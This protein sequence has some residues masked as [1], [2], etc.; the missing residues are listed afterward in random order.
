MDEGG[1]AFKVLTSKPTG[2][3]GRPRRIWR[4][5]IRIDIK[6]IRVSTRNWVD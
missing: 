1:T 2:L 5:N 3:L 4:D 6:E